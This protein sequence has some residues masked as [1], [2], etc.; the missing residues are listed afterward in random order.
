MDFGGRLAST[1]KGQQTVWK[2]LSSKYFRLEGHVVSVTTSLLTVAEGSSRQ[3]V[4]DG[5]VCV[6]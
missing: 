2:E 4:N 5:R 6:P 1:H 3:Y